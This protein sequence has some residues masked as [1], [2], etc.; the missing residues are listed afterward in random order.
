M[1]IFTSLILLRFYNHK[2]TKDTKKLI[3][4]KGIPHKQILVNLVLSFDAPQSPHR[5]CV[6]TIHHF[7]TAGSGL[8][9]EP[10]HFGSIEDD[11]TSNNQQLALSG[12]IP[13]FTR[14][15]ARFR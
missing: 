11:W 7:F 9:P 4:S 15:R 5:L 2:V 8:K 10:K 6:L 3:H 14:T 1:F 13:V 12:L